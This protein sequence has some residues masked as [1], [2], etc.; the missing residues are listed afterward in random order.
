MNKKTLMIVLLL[1]CVLGTVVNV[2]IFIIQPASGSIVA[3]CTCALA[4]ITTAIATTKV[5]K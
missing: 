4:T 2:V 3:L 5:N 1:I